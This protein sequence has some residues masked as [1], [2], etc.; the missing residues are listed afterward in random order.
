MDQQPTL[1]SVYLTL[2]GLISQD[3]ASKVF[4]IFA[5]IV[6]DNYDEVHMLVQSTGGFVG[7]GVALY[8]FLSSLPISL[9]TYNV[10]QVS[11]IAVPVYL[12][13]G[14]RIAAE[15]ASFMIHRSTGGTQ[16][17]SAA[18][19]TAAA[20]SLKIDDERT[21]NILKS[22]TNLPDD[23][24]AASAAHDLNFTAQEALQFGFVHEIGLF[25]PPKGAQ[26]FHI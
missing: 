19:L 18:F 14:K 17:G 21:T 16:G 5:G 6:R 20:N 9:T 22:R 8:N 15:T 4:G 26:L 23:K 2:A 11:S 7:D 24:W 3:L 10:G 25:V 1:K 13:G 12:G